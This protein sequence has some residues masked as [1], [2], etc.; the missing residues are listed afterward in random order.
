[1]KNNPDEYSFLRRLFITPLFIW[2]TFKY[3]LGNP[4][5]NKA[6]KQTMWLTKRWIFR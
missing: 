5:I 3:S 2:D 1:M 4:D 6:I